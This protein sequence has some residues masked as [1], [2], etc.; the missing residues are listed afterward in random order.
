MNTNASRR[1]AFRI[2]DNTTV[3]IALRAS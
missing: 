1:R 3:L 2:T